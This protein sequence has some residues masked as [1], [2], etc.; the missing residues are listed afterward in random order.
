MVS[1]YGAHLLDAGHRRTRTPTA[2]A[3][4]SNLFPL[5]PLLRL[6]SCGEPAIL[7]KSPTIMTDIIEA[8]RIVR[9]SATDARHAAFTK[10]GAEAARKVTEFFLAIVPVPDGA[11][12]AGYWPM[13]PELDDRPLLEHLHWHGHVCALPVV[14]QRHHP[15]VFHRWEPGDKLVAGVFGTSMPRHDTPPIVPDVLVVPLLAFDDEGYRLGYGGGYY[16]RTIAGLRKAGNL[17][18]V[19]VGFSAQRAPFVPHDH[20]DERLDWIVTETGAQKIG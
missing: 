10:L 9:A 13:G 18:T 17:L 14:E 4:P 8:K 3:A 1:V 2:K 20:F 15:L 16:D 5:R 11:A 12:V 6:L 7:F 19:G